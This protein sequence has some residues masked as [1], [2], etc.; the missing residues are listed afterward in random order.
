MTSKFIQI[1]D[2]M[3]NTPELENAAEVLLYANIYAFKNHIFYGAV[4]TLMERCKVT[5][6][7]TMFKYL[8]RLT[9][10]GLLKKTKINGRKVMY[11]VIREPIQ[12]TEPIELPEEVSIKFD[13]FENIVSN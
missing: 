9:E 10:I 8:K 11:A 7:N 1:R 13:T 12:Y 4:S 2:F 5:N 6:R 3:I